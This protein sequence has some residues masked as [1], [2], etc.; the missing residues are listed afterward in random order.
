MG[1]SYDIDKALFR[2]NSPS[3]NKFPPEDR[4]RKTSFFGVPPGAL[5]VLEAQGLVE[6]RQVTEDSPVQWRRVGQ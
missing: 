1:S 5:R 3:L 2:L 6:R 4:W